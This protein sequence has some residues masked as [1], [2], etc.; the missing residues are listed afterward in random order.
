VCGRFNLTASGE[1]LAEAFD[2]EEAPESAP[3]YNIAPSQ[4]VLVVRA[5]ARRRRA[6]PMRWGV[7]GLINARSETASAKASFRDAFRARRCLVPAS[8]FY[9][10]KRRRGE[11]FPFHVRRRDGGLLALAGLWSPGQQPGDEGCV[12]LTTEPNSVMAPIHDRMPVILPPQSFPLWLEGAAGRLADLEALLRPL[13]AAEL[14][15]VPVADAVNDVRNEGPG[16]LAPA[17]PSPRQGLLF[18]ELDE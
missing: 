3:R 12:I 4:P 6:G 2:L 7:D 9:E 16:C 18:P 13:P 1:E 11:S 10:W 5:Q 17:P 14:L 15:A 8:G